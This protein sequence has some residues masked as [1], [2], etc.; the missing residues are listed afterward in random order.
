MAANP[1]TYGDMDAF[2]RVSREPLRPWQV[3]AVQRLDQLWMEH[4]K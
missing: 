1:I 2:S 4:R 3:E